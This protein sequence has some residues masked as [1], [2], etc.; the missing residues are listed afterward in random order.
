MEISLSEQI[1]DKSESLVPVV[2]GPNSLLIGTGGGRPG[3][4][5]VDVGDGGSPPVQ[6]VNLCD[7]GFNQALSV[8]SLSVSE[9]RNYLMASTRNLVQPQTM[10][11]AQ[12][13]VLLG[14]SLPRL[15]SNPR[16]AYLAPPGPIRCVSGFTAVSVRDNG[17]FL[18]GQGDG[19]I[20]LFSF[21]SGAS[22]LAAAVACPSGPV[23]ACTAIPEDR[24]ATI[25]ADGVVRVWRQNGSILNSEWESPKL[26][27][28]RFGAMQSLHWCSQMDILL[29]GAGDGRVHFANLA[30]DSQ[31][32]VS[33]WSGHRGSV[34]SAVWHDEAEIVVSVGLEDGYVRGWQIKDP[35]KPVFECSVGAQLIGACPLLNRRVAMITADGRVLC[36]ELGSNRSFWTVATVM[37]RSWF[38]FPLE[39][40][41]ADRRIARS[42]TRR[43]L[44]RQA[45]RT[46]SEENWGELETIVRKIR[47]CGHAYE[48]LLLK[49]LLYRKRGQVLLEYKIWKGMTERLPE[50]EL[51]YAASYGLGDVLLRLNE[52]DQAIAAFGK[53][54]IFEDAPHR[55]ELAWKH[56]L[57]GQQDVVR[58]DIRSLQQMFLE[59]E[60]K[61]TFDQQFYSLVVILQRRL[62]DRLWAESISSQ[63]LLARLRE[64]VRSTAISDVSFFA[65]TRK[66][67]L[68]S[69]F[70]LQTVDWIRMKQKASE[71]IAP[72]F[73]YAVS[74]TKG[75]EGYSLDQYALFDA[76]S[77]VGDGST[78]CILDAWERAG[79]DRILRDWWD[80]VEDLVKRTVRALASTGPED[81]GLFA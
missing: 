21:H 33:S 18:A 52:P 4:Y 9:N 37:A 51:L 22:P 69:T 39:S 5:M 28:V 55:L 34:L 57:V 47:S 71:Q 80:T 65:E 6:L 25:G 56:P 48:A 7:Y 50:G 36:Y 8:Y 49:A 73:Q 75:V 79:G 44:L 70:P 72:Y 53:A 41:I 23:F 12:P 13:G 26:P 62:S 19:R 81:E 31:Y 24:W 11:V 77:V 16:S 1:S 78:M 60:K 15:L 64:R 54:G 32:G 2:F 10:S 58:A 14:W 27:P 35:S 42:Q 43:E 63:F 76:A 67:Y 46:I 29:W 66:L 20:L 68:D 40:A 38:S 59:L 74:L 30:T 3:I 61:A 45:E 17:F